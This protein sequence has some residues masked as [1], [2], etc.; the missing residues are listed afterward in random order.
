MEAY[1]VEDSV[2]VGET[3]S[4]N[5]ANIISLWISLP[6]HLFFMIHVRELEFHN[7]YYV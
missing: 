3:W 1:V 5:H 6:S 4:M 7:N 2:D